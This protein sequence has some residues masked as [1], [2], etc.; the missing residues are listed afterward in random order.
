MRELM[1]YSD[2]IKKLTTEIKV[3]QDNIC[4]GMIEIGNRL[5]EIKR[6]LGHGNWLP[7]I[8][9]ELGYSRSTASKFIMVAK[10]CKNIDI[11]NFKNLNSTII[12]E[13]L[14]LPIEVRDDIMGMGDVNLQSISVREFKKHV[15]VIKLKYKSR[16]PIPSATKKQLT[17]RSKGK[18]EICGKGNEFLASWLVEHHVIEYSKTQDNSMDN[19]VM[20]C[21]DCHGFIHTIKE[22]NDD[23]VKEMLLTG[24]NDLL[25]ENTYSNILKYIK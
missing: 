16:K 19:L 1:V 14:S 23:T 4:L 5:I 13:L 12:S 3:I 10:Q 21:P 6:E 15:N 22:C 2:N 17:I 18:C 24:M 20:I 9:K 7:Y 11:E 25:G 8:D